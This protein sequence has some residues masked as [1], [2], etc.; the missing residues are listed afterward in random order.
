MTK[1]PECLKAFVDE[2]LERIHRKSDLQW[3]LFSTGLDLGVDGADQAIK[4]L[5]K[6]PKNFELVCNFRARADLS[7]HERRC[8]D[9]LFNELKPLHLSPAVNKLHAEIQAL[10]TKLSDILNK[11]RPIL[12]GIE[13]PTV[14]I[15]QE[16]RSNPDRDQR[17]LAYEAFIPINRILVDN[18]FLSL[19][20]LRRQ[21]AIET[22]N[23][24]FVEYKLNESEL[25]SDL[26]AGLPDALKARKLGRNKRLSEIGQKYLGISELHPWDESYL[27]TQIAPLGNAPVD[28]SQFYPPIGRI[29]KKF[30]FDL[31]T[32]NLTYDIFPRKNK[33]EWGYNFTLRVGRDSRILTSSDSVYLSYD[34]LLHETAHGVHFLGLD[35]ENKVLNSAVSGIVAEGFANFFGCQVNSEYF[36]REIFGAERATR[37][38]VNTFHD[39][40]AHQDL[41]VFRQMCDTLFDQELY[42]QPLQS[43]DDINHLRWSLEKELLGKTSGGSEP[44]WARIIHYTVAPVYLHNYFMGDALDYTL[45]AQFQ[46]QAGESVSSDPTGYGR[47][48]KSRLLDPSGTLPFGELVQSACGRGIDFSGYLDSCLGLP[49]SSSSQ[50]KN[51]TPT[52]LE[53]TLTS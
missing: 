28:L 44:A 47:F 16:L 43:L 17:R 46:A 19:I 8:A 3:V 22:A 53:M 20:E 7:P 31:A 32:L 34:T 27:S 49:A 38:V 36:L 6:D 45:H 42:R 23:R 11:T 26:F 9:I 51:Q 52:R 40:R 14:K 50:I 25:S 24:D 29:F 21:L 4:E 37:E 41:S 15:Y 5:E 33:S 1:V 48:W 2:R 18:G 13:V 35:P 12:R 30:G 10:E 39:L